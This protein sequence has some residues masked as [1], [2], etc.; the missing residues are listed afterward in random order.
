MSCED[1]RSQNSLMAKFGIPILENKLNLS[2]IKISSLEDDLER[3]SDLI[4]A[5]TIRNLN[6]T[7]FIRIASRIRTYKFYESI[8][9]RNQ[10]T[11]RSRSMYGKNKTEYQKVIEG[12][13]DYFFYAFESE[14][15]SKI[16]YYKIID[17]RS[18]RWK[19][20]NYYSKILKQVENDKEKKWNGKASGI[21]TKKGNNDSTEFNYFND[22]HF[23]D[24]FVCKAGI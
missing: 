14:D 24:C 8:E 18:F 1:S 11:F 9:F 10:F 20:L 17:L 21:P 6:N 12:W 2:E 23:E 15:R 13:G 22:K 16:I 7:D 3:N 19:L 4:V 5:I